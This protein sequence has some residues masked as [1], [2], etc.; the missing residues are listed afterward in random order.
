ME[1]LKS[2][3]TAPPLSR[4][5]VYY[6]LQHIESGE[7]ICLLQD[8]IDHLA[9]FSVPDGARQFRALLG[10]DDHVDVAA[11]T[12]SNVPFN[13]Y[14]YNGEMIILSTPLS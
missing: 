10:I 11:V 12:P 3:L 14:W 8:G 4:D 9:V 7:Y 2:S 13:Y 1:F 6:A 5:G